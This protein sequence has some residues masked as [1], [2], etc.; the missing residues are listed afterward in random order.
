MTLEPPASVMEFTETEM[1]SYFVVHNGNDA[2]RAWSWEYEDWF[3]EE[4]AHHSQSFLGDIRMLTIFSIVLIAI[5][6]IV[7]VAGISKYEEK[8]L[9]ALNFFTCVGSEEKELRVN[10]CALFTKH[11]ESTSKKEVSSVGKEL[12]RQTTQVILKYEAKGGQVE[13]FK[14]PRSVSTRRPTLL[15]LQNYDKNSQIMIEEEDKGEAHKEAEGK[16]CHEE[17]EEDLYATKDALVAEQK[18]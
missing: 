5:V 16:Y 1:H 8:K 14:R 9:Q 6:C 4:A 12:E 18:E 2:I 10:S 11:L 7:L 13:E 17:R 15:R 3:V